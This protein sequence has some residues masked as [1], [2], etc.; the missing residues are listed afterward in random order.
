M[1]QALLDQALAKIAQGHEEELRRVTE[2]LCTENA[3]LTRQ[4][5]RLQ[6]LLSSAS[7]LPSADAPPT[8]APLEMP[9]PE[10]HRPPFG[11]AENRSPGSSAAYDKRIAWDQILGGELQ[12]TP[13][14]QGMSAL[15]KPDGDQ[16]LDL[17]G[18]V[19]KISTIPN[20]EIECN[21]PATE[22]TVQLLQEPDAPHS[23]MDSLGSADVADDDAWGVWRSDSM[24]IPEHQTIEDGSDDDYW[25]WH[26]EDDRAAHWLRGAEHLAH[27][28][29]VAERNSPPWTPDS[30]ETIADESVE[31]AAGHPALRQF[32]SNSDH[33][34]L[35]RISIEEDEFDR[36]KRPIDQPVAPWNMPSCE[37]IYLPPRGASSSSPS[38]PAAC[39]LC[40]TIGHRNCEFVGRISM[41]SSVTDIVS[42]G[43][44]DDNYFKNN[45][46]VLQLGVFASLLGAGLRLALCSTPVSTT[47][48]IISSLGG[49]SLVANPQSLNTE[50]PGRV[51]RAPVFLLARMT[52][53]RLPHAADSRSSLSLSN[54]FG[55]MAAAR[56][57]HFS[58]VAFLVLS[59]VAAH[60]EITKLIMLGFTDTIAGLFKAWGV[61]ANDLGNVSDHLA[62]SLG[63]T[64]IIA[65]LFMAWGIGADYVANSFATSVGSKAL[66]L[67]QA[68]AIAAVY[69]FVGCVSMSTSVTDTVCSGFIQELLQKQPRGA[70]AGVGSK[71]PILRQAAAIATANSVADT[72]RSGFFIENHF[73]NNPEVP[74]LGISASL[75]GAGLRLV[76]CSTPASTIHSIRSSLGRE[77]KPG[78]VVL[79]DVSTALG[80]Y[81]SNCLLAGAHDHPSIDTCPLAALSEAW[82]PLGPSLLNGD[83]RVRARLPHTWE[84]RRSS[85]TFQITWQITLGFTGI[86]AGLFMAWGIGA[87]DVAN[88][89]ATSIGSK[90]L[91]LQQAVAIA[92]V[93]EFP[94]IVAT[95]SNAS[96]IEPDPVNDSNETVNAPEQ[97][98]GINESVVANASSKSA[99]VATESNASTVEPDPVNDSNETVKAPE[100]SNGINESDESSASNTSAIVAVAA[101]IANASGVAASSVMVA[102]SCP[103]RR[104]ASGLFARR[105]A[106]AVN[107]AYEISIPAGSAAIAAA[108]VTSAIVPEG[109]NGSVS[110][111][112]TA[113]IAANIVGVN[114][115]VTSVP[116]P[117]TTTSTVSTTA[118]ES[119]ASTVEP[120]PLLNGINESV[121]DNASSKSAVVAT[122]S[123]ASIVEPDPVNDSNETV[124]A[125]ELLNG[126]KESEVVN[127]SSESAVVATE[128]NA[129]TVEPDPVN[130]SNE[131]VNAPKLLNGINESVVVNVSSK[132]AIVAT[133][134]NASIVEPDPVNDSNETV[135]APE[136]L[137]GINESVVVNASS[138]SAIVTAKQRQQSRA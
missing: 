51:W 1:F 87:N 129:S 124:N 84:S 57:H 44:I 91:M 2:A 7:Q 71:A 135:N 90:A 32:P 45:P 70:A 35:C 109:A 107:A 41:G 131:T 55:S 101:G 81:R 53:L 15:V 28:V 19:D 6:M 59:P 138:K 62:N 104:L 49:I 65:G 63:F 64:C 100:L 4:L 94:S 73:K 111:I 105:L 68:V 34:P 38:V 121:V 78:G 48:S 22:S 88:S 54:A 56:R 74:Q 30:H 92:T 52:I 137:N 24:P 77:A 17:P 31:P 43:F 18:A 16:A 97:L 126:I 75:L 25:D 10:P 42:S 117:E 110:K 5:A 134:S 128:S 119:N 76:L 102:L 36:T 3:S 116:E 61:G 132:S 123:N 69:E 50:E 108:S 96:T 58:L 82:R 67:R 133:E 20:S 136:L 8:P 113:M 112:A 120:D 98:N 93:Y 95:M 66:I 127:A 114:L 60:M 103:S 86:I 29:R 47:R 115:T 40:G 33:R 11:V 72:V 122:K 80:H 118:A 130:D 23:P 83:Y 26:R 27:Q 14:N 85:A 106:D 13:T 79:A 46:E 12:G 39:E 99:V 125:P 89:F 9:I 21:R 37:T